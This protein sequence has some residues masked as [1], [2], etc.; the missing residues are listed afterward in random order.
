MTKS[1]FVP[2]YTPRGYLACQGPG[3]A[4]QPDR[5]LDGRF[6]PPRRATKGLADHPGGP[7]V[8]TV[9]DREECQP[10]GL[11]YLACRF[12]TRVRQRLSD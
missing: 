12:D 3:C 6:L 5:A 10:L 2:T 4:D 7:T 8:I 1:T 11:T 9:C